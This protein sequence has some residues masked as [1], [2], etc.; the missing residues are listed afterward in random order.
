[1]RGRNEE[2]IVDGIFVDDHFILKPSY[3]HWTVA[4]ALTSNGMFL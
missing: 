2:P 3:S 1:M 4:Y